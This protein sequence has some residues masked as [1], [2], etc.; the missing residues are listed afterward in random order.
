MLLRATKAGI[1][2][3]SL[4]RASRGCGLLGL[5]PVLF[6]TVC[7]STFMLHPQ[8]A[9]NAAAK[10]PVDPSADGNRP[11]VIALTNATGHRLIGWV[12]ASPSNHGVVLVGDGNAT[13]TAQTYAYNRHLLN[14]GYNV[15]FLSYQG[16]D[17]NGGTARLKSLSGDIGTF[18]QECQQRFLHQ[19][20]ALVG[21]SLSAGAFFCFASRQP[22]I[23]CLVLE[24]M[25]DLKRVAFT[26]L[27]ESWKLQLFYPVTWPTA[28]II[29]AT[30]PANLSAEGALQ[31]HPVIPALFIHQP[32]D[33]VTPYRDVRRVFD[34][35]E[36][37]KELLIP[38]TNPQRSSH[39]T[40]NFDPET[41][42]R[43]IY[44]PAPAPSS[45][46]SQSAKVTICN[47]RDGLRQHQ[48]G[49]LRRVASPSFFAF[50]G[51]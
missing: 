6:L 41:R 16:F 40:A 12:F 22:E 10:W 4:C 33:S 25:P 8:L 51:D 47:R 9:R 28:W 11:E 43:V 36:G 35:Y 37:P 49:A 21:E 14:Q 15:V 38:Q 50:V 31:Q 17:A 39:M 27:D 2:R 13:G 5:L 42:L 46:E 45:A 24:S 18:Y 19:P 30:V 29:S 23:S 7:A 3:R 32:Q 34:E 26:L 1:C 44:I 20:I 48:D